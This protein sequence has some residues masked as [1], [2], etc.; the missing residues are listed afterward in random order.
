M[1]I[2]LVKGYGTI[3]W[4]L[5]C[6][7]TKGLLRLF[8]YAKTWPQFYATFTKRSDTLGI[9]V[10]KLTEYAY[11]LCITLAMENTD[12][13]KKRVNK[14]RVNM[15]GFNE[16]V[17]SNIL[18]LANN[19]KKKPREIWFLLEAALN[20]PRELEAKGIKEIGMDSMQYRLRFYEY[21][22][23]CQKLPWVD[24]MIKDLN[25]LDGRLRRREAKNIG[26]NAPLQN[27]YNPY[28]NIQYYPNQLTEEEMSYPTTTSR[29]K[30]FSRNGNPMFQQYPYVKRG[31]HG[32]GSRAHQPY[33]PYQ[34][35]RQ[36][37]NRDRAK[38]S[39]REKEPRTRSRSRSRERKEREHKRQEKVVKPDFVEGYESNWDKKLSMYEYKRGKF[40]GK[41]NLEGRICKHFE[42]GKC[43]YG[44][45]R[46]RWHHMC[47][48]CLVIGEHSSRDCPNR[49]DMTI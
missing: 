19:K 42:S 41:A 37:E 11:D 26:R 31:R 28:K 14:I 9:F 16:F 43:T 4:L 23:R 47:R 40:H 49:R 24:E 25:D 36:R 3:K 15:K 39:R 17:S 32:Y 35:Y 38:E 5:K 34:P 6:L 12:I 44:N 10:S 46:C 13:T 48:Y 45:K 1:S 33:R 8:D 29:P 20:L 22:S 2:F 27:D 21:T 30:L 7:I 18:P